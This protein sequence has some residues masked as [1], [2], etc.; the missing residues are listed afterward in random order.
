[1]TVEH[2]EI[3]ADFLE[4]QLARENLR[5]FVSVIRAPL[6]PFNSNWP[7]EELTWYQQEQLTLSMTAH[8]I[9]LLLIDGPPAYQAN[10][11]HARYPAVPFFAPLFAE[12]YAI[13]LDDIDR[14][15]ERDIMKLWERDF[16]IAFERRLID[17]GIGIG[18]PRPPAFSI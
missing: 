8:P 9:D 3:W 14:K 5:H 6:V 15:G 7:D 10:R 1:L 17:G 2:D 11:T 4:E 16:G 18:R 12:D 13:I